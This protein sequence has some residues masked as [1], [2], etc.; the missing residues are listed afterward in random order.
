MCGDADV[1]RAEIVVAVVVVRHVVVTSVSAVLAVGKV[2]GVVRSV[3][4]TA[5]HTPA[6]QQ[7]AAALVAEMVPAT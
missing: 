7:D 2:Q 5:F 6:S 3:F 1:N 4:Q